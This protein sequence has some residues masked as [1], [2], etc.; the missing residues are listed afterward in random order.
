V[1]TN[2]KEYDHH[3][4]EIRQLRT[5]YDRNQL[6]SMDK[7]R[8]TNLINS[9]SGF[10]SVNLLGSINAQQQTNLAL[11]SSV[12]HVGANPPLMGC[13][14]RPHTVPRHSLENV[15]EMGC[16]TLNTVTKSLYKQAHQTSARY[17]RELSE[18][19]AV[20]L[21]PEYSDVLS[22]PYVAQSP[23]K[24]GLSLVETQTLSINE[25]VLVIGEIKEIRLSD[26][27]IAEDGHLKLSSM[28]AVALS[29]LDEYY[30]PVSLGRLPYPKP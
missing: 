6:D 18:F 12:F 27:M 4:G 19:E 25:T 17:P 21:T 28:E 30:L 26:D 14:L 7:H 9:L 20:G 10:K 16:F 3:K 24:I 11:M 1:R 29:G 8:R 15:V 13:L 22:A 5:S 23:V 2:R